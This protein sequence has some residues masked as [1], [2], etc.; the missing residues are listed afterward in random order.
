MSKIAQKIFAFLQGVCRLAWSELPLFVILVAFSVLPAYFNEFY[1]NS[2]LSFMLPQTILVSLLICWVA[3]QRRWLWYTVF[4]VANLIFFVELGCYF[5]QESR[6]NSAIAVLMLQTNVQESK[7]FIEFAMIPIAKAAL[8]SV[9][10]VLLLLFWSY[11]WRRGWKIKIKDRLKLNNRVVVC[12][13]GTLLSL[14]IVYTPLRLYQCFKIYDRYW[15]RMTP[16][17]DA[18]APVVYCYAIMDSFFNPEMR[19]L[20]MLAETI[21]NTKVQILNSKDELNIVYVIGES[22]GRIRSSM[23]GY[24]KCTNPYMQ[25]ELEDGSLIIFD[26]VLSPTSSTMEVYRYILSTCDILGDK[27]FVEYP[28]LPSILKKAGYHVS[29]YDNQG[30]INGAK[31]DFGCTFFFSNSDVRKQ[32]IDEYNS[33]IETY[34]GTF[35]TENPVRKDLPLSL[36][37]YHL[38]G[39]HVGFKGRYTPDFAKFSAKDYSSYGYTEQQ[40]DM[41]AAYDNATLYNDYVLFKIIEQLRDKVAVMIYV[42]DHGEEV[43]DY[44]DVMGRQINAPQESVRLLFEVPVMIWVSNKF[45]ELYPEKVDLLKLNGNKAIY[46]TDL[47]HTILDLAGVETESFRPDLSLLRECA[48]RTNRRILRNNFEYDANRDKVKSVKMRYEK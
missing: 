48:G 40:A 23:Y 11:Y 4:G 17:S 38:M 33:A 19:N 41:V 2:F 1:L 6:F 16:M 46:N 14:S 18:S 44:R 21:A 9:I 8:C 37:I 47:S 12:V 32:S 34:D 29:Y 20:D 43:Y 39:Q 27:S 25:R 24:P 42:P 28:L 15:R 22:F 35:I 13:I 30:V 5:C 7:E 45:K 36:T 3:S 10:I 26:N 31:L